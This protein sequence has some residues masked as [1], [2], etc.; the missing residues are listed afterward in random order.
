MFCVSEE[1]KGGQCSWTAKEE[2]ERNSG[3]GIAGGE[4]KEVTVMGNDTK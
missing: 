4:L 1:H 2:V 3:V